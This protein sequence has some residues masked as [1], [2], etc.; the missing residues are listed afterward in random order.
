[1]FFSSWSSLFRTLVVGTLAYV[2]LVMFL[3]ISGKRT[4]S[5]L[6]AFDLIVTV[7]LGSTLATVLISRD[8]ALADGAF[9]FALLIGLQFAVTWSSVRVKWV[10]S[11]VTGEPSL[12]LF[13]GE[14]LETA[15]R[16][17]RVTRDEVHAA[18]REAGHLD[19]RDV[20]AVVLETDGSIT[21]MK[22]GDSQSAPDSVSSLTDVRRHDK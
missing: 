14:L 4:L 1:M 16:R 17:T 12:L 6:N 22:R 2:T 13:R 20:E 11:F 8:V 15:L 9:A 21:V 18:V 5:K 3:R 7:S 19:L 10:R